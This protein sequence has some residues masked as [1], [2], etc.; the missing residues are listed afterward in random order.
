NFGDGV[1]LN[2]TLGPGNVIEGN[3]IGT[4]VSG[5]RI[6]ANRGNGVEI[7]ASDVQIGGTAPGA[8]NLI[9]G[10]AQDGILIAPSFSFFTPANG[11]LV[12]GNLI[13]TDATGT[14]PLGNGS[15][16][17]SISG[18]FIGA[19]NNTI[20]GTAVGAGNTIAYNGHNGV[21]VG[22]FSFDSS[23]IANP[24]LSNS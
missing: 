4:D 18:Q 6:L 12:Q 14:A 11:N 22:S 3:R 20:G 24:I 13:G 5:T 21:T 23:S 16:G 1:L 10:N 8:G 19:S 17:V 9:S 7:A 2:P 15:D